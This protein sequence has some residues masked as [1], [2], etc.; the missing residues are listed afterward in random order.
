MIVFDPGVALCRVCL[1]VDDDDDDDDDD[2]DE[3][4]AL[5]ITGGSE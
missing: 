5:K 1:R 2:G 3:P 4:P